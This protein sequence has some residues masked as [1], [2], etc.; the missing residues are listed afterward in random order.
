MYVVFKILNGMAPGVL[1]NCI[2]SRVE[3]RVHYRLRNQNDT[4]IPFTKTTILKLFF[5]SFIY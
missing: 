5:L 4:S 3:D 1:I 2:A